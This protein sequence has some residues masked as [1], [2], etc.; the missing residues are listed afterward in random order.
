LGDKSDC[1][2]SIF[3]NKF[4]NKIKK[5]LINSID[6]FNTF[7]KQNKSIEEKYNENN[8]LINFDF[9]PSNYTI[10]VVNEFNE[11]LND[12]KTKNTLF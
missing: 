3:P 4:P 12:L 9:I 8:K 1:I 7:I 2:T 11:I 10:L 5:E 6:S